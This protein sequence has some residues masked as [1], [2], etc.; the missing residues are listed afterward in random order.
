MEQREN[1]EQPG[2]RVEKN[3]LKEQVK[4]GINKYIQNMDLN[5]S[6]KL[7]REE[8]LARMLGVSRITLRSVLDEMSA[9]GIIFRKHG[10]G[11][12]VNPVFYEMNVSFNPVLHF[13]DMIRN[14]GYVPATKTLCCKTE[15][16]DEDTAQKLHIHPGAPVFVCVKAFY[17]DERMCAVVKDFIPAEVIG[18]L[19]PTLFKRFDESLFYYIYQKTGRKIVW[20]KVEIDVADSDGDRFLRAYT[21]ELSGKGRIFLLLKGVNYDQD[22]KEILY[23][24]EYIDTSILK[25]TQIRKRKIEYHMTDEWQPG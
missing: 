1:S 25:F 21:H 19:D 12:F 4:R 16:A 14:S 5:I 17:A 6:N 13:S 2:I 10:K 23:A 20:D 3:D 18:E 9:D 15:K 11:T 22:D 24:R 8:T 7:P